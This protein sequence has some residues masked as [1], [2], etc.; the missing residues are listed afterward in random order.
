MPLKIEDYALIGDCEAC[1]L[2]GLD[3]SIDWLCWPRF[4]SDACFAALLGTP[5]NGRWLIAPTDAAA[6]VTRS[7]RGDTL[8]LETRF[9]TAG[10]VATVIDFMPPRGKNP[11][12]V[13]IVRGDRG[14]VAFRSE[15]TLRF[16]YGAVTPWMTR[17][18]GGAHRAIAGPDMVILRTPVGIRGED[19]HSLGEFVVA[20]GESTPFTLSWAPS[21]TPPPQAISPRQALAETEQF[22]ADWSARAEVKGRWSEAARRS[23]ITLKALTHGPTGGVI[24]AAT[25][26]LP[27][28]IGGPRNW[29]YRYCW[30][31][32]ATLTL[33]ALMNAGY[34]DEAQAWRDWL[35]RAVAGSP[36][37]MHIMYG[38]AGERRLSEWEL[39]WLPGYEGSRPVR[40]GNAAH[41]QFQLDVYGELADSLHQARRGGL[42][43]NEAAWAVERALTDHVCR[44][45]DQPDDG[46][47]ED[48]ADRKHYTFSKVM[49][50]VA[51]DRAVKAVE[52]YGLPGDADR[53]RAVR[54]AIREHILERGF[55]PV[56]NTFVRDFGGRTLD[57][58][59]LL[60]A[61]LGFVAPDDP[62]FVGT[63]AAVEQDLL[64]DGFVM[65]YDTE[66]IDDG[67][68]PGEGAFLACSF[69]LVNA[70]VL[71]G[72]KADAV[73]LFER[74][75][76]LRNDVGLLAEEYDPVAGRQVGNF[77]QAFSHIG[78][79]NAA[80]N[81]GRGERP[82]EQRAE[83]QASE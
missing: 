50:W 71:L 34:Y 3:G 30:I 4:D 60:L 51:V 5:D 65:R 75:L 58:S 23:L 36:E 40:V 1:A 19:L 26:S 67:L 48:R 79:I 37:D 15:L 29:D 27:E 61:E 59:L 53:W 63:V 73:A 44:V 7:Y 9:E 69:W 6:T 81:L 70:Y 32:D 22:W 56:R 52:H 78:L 74:L 43:G 18:D 33:L 49:A 12:L 16:G 21:H 28:Q 8:I 41:A 82:S 14:R 57:A 20:E 24:A 64:R 55:D 46:I 25:T 47:W 11:E 10:G 35:L 83:L 72:R 54:E 13:R 77:P 62:R 80:F 17:T 31:R 66:C 42:T 68:P 76:A 39:D 2:V 45:W 38:V